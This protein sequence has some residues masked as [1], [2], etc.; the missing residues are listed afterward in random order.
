MQNKELASLLLKL[1]ENENISDFIIVLNG[2]FNQELVASAVKLIEEKCQESGFPQ[3]LITKLKLVSVEVLQNISKHKHNDI[4]TLPYFIIGTNAKMVS[5][6]SGNVVTRPV[7]YVI[8]DRLAVY[9]SLTTS[10]LKNFYRDSLRNTSVSEE[11]NA[12]IGL[13]D[14]VYRS[15]QKVTFSFSEYKDNLYHFGLNVNIINGDNKKD[16]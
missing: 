1:A 4:E 8:Q 14:I 11:G 7:K 2:D 16:Q 10:Q 3:T 15:N 9:T 12:G 13:L 5:I 6:Y